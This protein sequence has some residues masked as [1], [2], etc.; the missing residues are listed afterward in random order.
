M[1]TFISTNDSIAL[2]HQGCNYNI[3]WGELLMFGSVVDGTL[4]IVTLYQ[5]ITLHFSQDM[6]EKSTLMPVCLFAL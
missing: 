3:F 2:P 5:I 4:V 1:G 6:H